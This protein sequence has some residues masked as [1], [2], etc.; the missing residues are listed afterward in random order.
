MKSLCIVHTESSLEWTTRQSRIIA[1]AQ[2]LIGRGHEV[3]ILCPPGSRIL[4][5]AAPSLVPALALP[6][7]RKRPVGVK[8]LYEW[9]KRNRCDVLSTHGATDAWLAALALLALGRPFATVRTRHDAAP[10]PRNVPTR[11]LYLR[12]TARV[13]CT[14][15]ACRKELIERNGFPAHRV[16]A[17]PDGAGMAGRMEEIYRSVAR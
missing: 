10:V 14:D 5:E 3:R 6:I 8:V 16:D 13:V 2:A 9:F 12:A 1:E 17:V 7:A 15:E 11:W 4:A